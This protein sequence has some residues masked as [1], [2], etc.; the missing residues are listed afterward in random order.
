MKVLSVSASTT[1]S[2]KLFHLL[3]TRE[4]KM[5]IFLSYNGLHF[6]A[7]YIYFPL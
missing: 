7:T 2:G 4:Q 6:S 1:E 5:K 3:T